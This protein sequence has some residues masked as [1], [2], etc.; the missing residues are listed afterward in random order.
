MTSMTLLSNYTDLARYF[1]YENLIYYQNH[2][3]FRSL[4]KIPSLGSLLVVPTAMNVAD[5]VEYTIKQALN[6]MNNTVHT[7]PNDLKTAK[8]LSKD[9]TDSIHEV[10]EANSNLDTVE[11][12]IPNM[13]NLLNGLNQIQNSVNETGNDLYEKIE[14]LKRKIT[15]A[16]ELADRFKTGLKFFKNTTL[17][18]KNP[19]SLPLLATSTKVSLFFKTNTLNGLLMYLGNEVKS[20]DPRSKS[21]SFRFF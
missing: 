15:N 17:E 6:N 19:E 13:K 21:V 2:N 10:T 20:K 12:V 14:R 7:L 3:C 9:I 5:K 11:K 18:L 16:R 8:Q 1:V 4:K